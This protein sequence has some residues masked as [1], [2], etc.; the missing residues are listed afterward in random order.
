MRT[1]R[2]GLFFFI[3]EPCITRKSSCKRKTVK[4]GALHCPKMAQEEKNG[5]SR[6]FAL[7]ENGPGREK[8]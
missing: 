2:N 4:A 3:Q 1:G 8:R 6:S 5:K 7:P